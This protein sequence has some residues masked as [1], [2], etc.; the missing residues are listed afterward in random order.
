MS[1]FEE[2]NFIS[3]PLPPPLSNLYHSFKNK[4]WQ[5]NNS[6]ETN[7]M[8]TNQVN[9]QTFSYRFFVAY[10]TQKW[11][12]PLFEISAQGETKCL[13]VTKRIKYFFV[14]F[15]SFCSLKSLDLETIHAW[16]LLTLKI[17]VNCIFSNIQE[18]LFGILMW[19]LKNLICV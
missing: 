7:T 6:N 9:M 13:K 12:N 15:S 3:L 8:L 16:T 17:T 5:N 4:C 14:Y 1:I 19:N 18:F 2:S 10:T 11:P